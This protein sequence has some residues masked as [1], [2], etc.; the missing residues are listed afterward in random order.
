M[1]ILILE[2]AQNVNLRPYESV[3]L[4]TQLRF[5]NNEFG[6]IYGYINFDNQAGLEQPFLITEEINI[7]Y[8]QFV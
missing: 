2:K 8:M 5:T 6:V 4:R 3:L 1:E 7:D